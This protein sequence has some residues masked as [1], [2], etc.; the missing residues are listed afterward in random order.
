MKIRRPPDR[1]PLAPPAGQCHLAYVDHAAAVVNLAI[2]M[3]AG[4]SWR[5]PVSVGV[6]MR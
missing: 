3:V 5:T 4:C 6:L 1:F 2:M